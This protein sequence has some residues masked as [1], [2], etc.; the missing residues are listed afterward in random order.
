MSYRA[1][2]IVLA[3][4]CGVCGLL[5]LTSRATAATPAQEPRPS[6]ATPGAARTVTATVRSVD[7]RARV[8]DLL[9]GV[10][11]A[12]RIVRISVPEGCPIRVKAAAAGLRDLKPGDICRVEFRKTAALN[13][14]VRIEVQD[15]AG[16]P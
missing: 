9:T 16:R 3:S 8:V 4:V 10:G 7:D 12:L 14:A 11:H 6:T 15:A 13:V 5:W 1:V 2:Q